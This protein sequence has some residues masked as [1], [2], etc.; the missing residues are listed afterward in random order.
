MVL[1]GDG[2]ISTTDTSA[3]LLSGAQNNIY[4]GGYFNGSANLNG[5]IKSIQYYPL[6]LSNA[7][8][9]ALTV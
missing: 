9:Q 5:H 8:L 6:G 1:A 2:N 3:N 7:Q 4:I